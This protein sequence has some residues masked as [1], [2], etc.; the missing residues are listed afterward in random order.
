MACH[1]GPYDCHLGK[2]DHDI[3]KTFISPYIILCHLID[4]VNSIKASGLSVVCS[5][6]SSD[7]MDKLSSDTDR[8]KH[9]NVFP[10]LA[11]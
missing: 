6:G 7:I 10:S 11:S 4:K 5:L 3:N 2:N 9:N 1:S 8:T